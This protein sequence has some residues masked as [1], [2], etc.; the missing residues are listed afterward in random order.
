ML[1]ENNPL[2]ELELNTKNSYLNQITIK[3]FESLY[4]FF[5]LILEEPIENFWYEYFG[6]ILGYLQIWFYFFNSTVNY[7][8]FILYSFL[9]FGTINK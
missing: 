7:Y 5:E 1:K 4:E 9:R 8:I 6:I 3:C 2:L